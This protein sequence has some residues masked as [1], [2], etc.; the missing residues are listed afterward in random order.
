[1]RKLLLIDSHALLHRLFH[2]VAP[3]TTPNGEPIGAIY[4]LS[5]L[6]MRILTETIKPDYVAACFDRPEPTFRKETYAEYKAHRG[7]T[8]SELIPQLIRSREVFANFKIK[9]F[10]LAGFE[11]DDLIA[12]LTEK[13]KH[14]KDLQIL[15]F[16]GDR[17]LLQLV[18][19][20]K[21]VVELF[22]QGT[23][24]T[25]HMNE[26]AVIEK[27]GLKPLQIVD[28]KG[29]IGDASDNIPGV[30]NVGEKTA[31][32]LLQ[33]FGTVEEVFENL[34]IVPQKVAK[35]FEGQ[36]EVALMSKKLATVERNAP[37]FLDSLDDLRALLLDIQGLTAYFEKLGFV[38]LVRRLTEKE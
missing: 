38:S 29:L 3:L 35:K 9:C 26:A 32:P 31:T 14:E 2:A 36:R 18:E 33:E 4:G 24:E 13:L 16:T 25:M 5:Q 21:V 8:D 1:M 12:T 34:V 27:Y 19:G 17:D 15:I 23:Q 6:L 10:E 28:L 11:A 22:K 7:P 20:D 30:M 37:I